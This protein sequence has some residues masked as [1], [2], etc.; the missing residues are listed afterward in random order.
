MNGQIYR[1]ARPYDIATLFPIK[2]VDYLYKAKKY[3]DFFINLSEFVLKIVGGNYYGA[4]KDAFNFITHFDDFK[5]DMLYATRESADSYYSHTGALYMIN[6]ET[7]TV[8]HC[9]DF[10]N[11]ERDHFL[12]KNHHLKI[13]I[14][15]ISEIIEDFHKNRNYLTLDQDIM[16][17]CQKKKLVLLKFLVFSSIN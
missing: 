4:V 2:E 16:G 9:D 7:N 14:S 6:D 5:E 10:Y 13:S 3:Y 11:E 15:L 8:Y 12:C 1:I 17:G